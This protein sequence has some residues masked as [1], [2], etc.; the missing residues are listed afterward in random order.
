MEGRSRGGRVP[1]PLP[2]TAGA[3]TLRGAAYSHPLSADLTVEGGSAGGGP[4]RPG[5]VSLCMPI[6]LSL[7]FLGVV[8]AAASLGGRAVL[9]RL[10]EDG[11]SC[12][13]SGASGAAALGYGVLALLPRPPIPAAALL[14]LLAVAGALGVG[15][16][17]DTASRRLPHTVAN[18][19]LAAVSAAALAGGIRSAAARPRARRR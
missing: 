4:P 3:A 8:L 9:I 19:T 7:V 2:K 17:T 10:G 6:G 12:A 13:L 1:A 14:P 11:P 18:T 15:W 5:V 16:T